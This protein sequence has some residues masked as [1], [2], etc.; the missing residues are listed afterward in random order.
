[1]P[2]V[3]TAFRVGPLHHVEP[4][5][6]SVT[7]PGGAVRLEPK[8]MQVLVCLAEH[9]PHVVAKEQLM[10]A[11]WADTFVTD[12]V[13]TRSISELRR[14]FGDDAREPRFIETIP[15][16]GYRL[17]A[18]VAAVAVPVVPRVAVQ[19]GRWKV[20]TLLGL[21]GLF[22]LTL[23]PL[24]LLRR[25]SA[26]P[27]SPMRIVPLTTLN[28]SEYGGTFSPDGRQVA[29]AWNGE[30]AP[31]ESV[32]TWIHGNWDIYVKVIGAVEVRRLTTDAALDLA[33][34][35]SPDGRQ[36]AYVRLAP[37][38]QQ[39][40]VMSALGGGDRAV[41]DFPVFL[42]AAWS[43]DSRYLAAGRDAPVD[44]TH[45]NGI[46][47]IPLDGGEPRAITR[48]EGRS[49]DQS[50]IFSPDG[51][52][53]A[54]AA[55]DEFRGVCA[56]KVAD[57]DASFA[58]IG[59][60]RTVTGPLGIGRSGL[61]WTRDGRSIV[62][63]A[64]SNQLSYLWRVPADGSRPAE[65]VEIAG[66]NALF[67]SASPSD[68]R[69]VFTRLFHDEDIYRLGATG[70]AEP[71]ARSSFYDGTP[72]YSP[73]G[74]Q[75]AFAS[76]RSG[77]A[78]DVWIAN[79][80]GSAPKQLTRG[81]GPF[82][83]GPAWSP[84]GR[85]I[86]LESQA[87]D[88]HAHV[89]TIANDGSAPRQIT[90]DPGDQMAPSWSRDGSWLYYSWARGSERDIWRV[91]TSGGAPERVTTGG[92][93]VAQESPDGTSLYYLSQGADSPLVVQSLKGGAPHPVVEC[94]IGTAFV[95]RN[96]SIYYVPCTG[97]LDP[98]PIVRRRDLASG[99]EHE[100]G[101]LPSFQYNSLPSGFD[102]SPDG[103]NVLYGRL[104]RDEADLM[105]IENFR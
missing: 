75:I 13:L 22:A 3:Q 94:I 97:S 49:V 12:D 6:N 46:H 44:A 21:L 48:P 63:N 50:P 39:L 74:R 15:K 14:V 95:V 88:G 23:V 36:I 8:V 34:Q 11:V 45:T 18:P 91:R 99:A 102:V 24:W 35:W 84:D 90:K 61:T 76:M 105:M 60:P 92:G 78:I 81:P 51:H 9:A 56:V 29:F 2:H 52:R 55:C 70:A 82:Q 26:S 7:G 59:Q 85:R 40:R 86:A 73:D 100:I 79:A 47:L 98:N 16:S 58:V 87:A 103:L 27:V 71:V 33:P 31:G 83:G 65:K 1:M 42:P 93:F 80:D 67:P 104:V 57:L 17:I 77:E 96:S 89:W 32:R 72:Q 37:H 43:P 62:F 10:R 28:G 38:G 4:A 53:L 68:D 30:L 64:E 69:L 54:Y 66:V 5:L 25:G 41:S 19:S 20:A 101:R